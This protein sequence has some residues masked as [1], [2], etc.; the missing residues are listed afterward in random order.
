MAGQLRPLH[1]VGKRSLLLLVAVVAVSNAPLAVRTVRA[2]DPCSVANVNPIPCENA[3]PGT[4]QSVWSVSGAGDPGI[5]GF[6]TDI[7]VNVGGTISFKVGT[8]STDYSLTIY[9]L[10]YY[11]NN[12]AR[13]IATV[14]PSA[15]LPQSQPACLTDAPTGLIDCG[16]W[17]V[18]ASWTVPTTAVSGLYFARVAD[19]GTGAASQIWFVVRDDAA[20]SDVLFRT[21]DTTWEAYNDYGGNSVY[22][23]SAPSSN[24]RAYK[25]SYNR[26]FNNRSESAGF[27]TVN[28]PLY[29]E[30]PMI[31]WLEANGYDV[32][33]TSTVDVERAPALLEQHKVFLTSGHDEYWSAGERSAVLAARDAGVG[34]AFFTGNTSFWKIRWESSI[35]GSGTPYRTLVTYKESLDQRVLDPQDPPTWTGSWRDPR[36]SPPADGGQPENAVLGTIFTVNRG[37]AAPVVGSDFAGLRFWRNTAIAGLTAGQ[38]VTLGSNTIGYEW[39]EDLD[40]GSR[41][42]GLFDLSATPVSV[43]QKI[44]DYGVSYGP[45]SATH[46]LTLYRAASG[47]LVFSA[48]TVQ[49]AWGLDVLGHDSVP[50][51]GPVTADRNMQQATVNLL[52]DMGVQP[53]TLQSGLVA[54]T[55][56]TDTTAPT[57]A[58]TAPAAGATVASGSQVTVSGTAS[59]VGGAVAGVEV[60]ADGGATWHRASGTTSWTYAWTPGAPGPTALRSR[61]VD[62]SGN[63]ETPSAGVT[64]TVTPPACPCSL[65]PSLPVPGTPSSQDSNA[66]EVGVRFTSDVAGTVTGVSFYKGSGNTGAHVGNLWTA[67]GTLLAT[68]TF[69]NET[70]SGWQTLTFGAPVSIQSHTVYVASYHTTSGFYSSDVGYYTKQVDSWPLHAPAGFNGVFAYGGTQFPTQ[71]FSANNYWVDVV[72]AMAG[73]TTAL[74]SSANP[75]VFGQPVTLTATVSGSGAGQPAGTVAFSDG[76][77]QIGSATLNGGSPDVATLTVPGLAV[78]GHSLTAVYA[79]SGVYA[80]STSPALAQQVNKAATTSSLTASPSPATPGQAVTLTAAVAVVAPGA[81]TPTGTVA[82]FDGATQLGTAPLSGGHA[83]LST[84]TLS[85][86]T[87]TLKAAYQG[88]PNFAGS[89]SAPVSEVVQ[90]TATTL[91]A[92]PAVLGLNPL[93]LTL[94]NLSATLT[95]TDT[96]A[97]VPGQTITMTA[98]GTFLCSATTNSAGVAT[99]NGVAGVLAILLKGG[100]TA[101]FAGT[102]TYRGST[103]FGP[104]IS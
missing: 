18:S 81:G 41:P 1:V 32:S 35:D 22:Y 69:T 3:Q 78:G 98:G 5:Q 54:A 104:A 96:G 12:G 31:K 37:S 66:V 53:A 47:A 13:Q 10:G 76:S 65:F 25:V 29:A 77:T 34:M 43:P 52:A 46:S 49:W 61:A 38:T 11:Q 87:H 67:T 9:R 58:V 15:A 6:A 42:A 30:Y 85:S 99:C 16:N 89:T 2:V 95:R 23:G 75:P 73:T 68:G 4:P 39:D 57:S 71:T 26:P 17:A 44:R 93:R 20:A 8:A 80:S 90:Q 97:P 27:G 28:G 92:A 56:S 83:S 72:F 101:T 86:G 48:A 100:Y 74:A 7:S 36:W 60:S 59:D 21:N 70:A 103:A 82:F 14:Q 88:D 63:L 51:F 62:D 40:N 24:G 50:D 45:G 55:A 79:G 64:V 19:N 91:K 84:T 102:A 94:L 33:Y